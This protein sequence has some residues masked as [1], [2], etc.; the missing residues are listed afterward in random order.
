MKYFLFTSD[1]S[2]P[3]FYSLERYFKYKFDRELLEN[4]SFSS[5]KIENLTL[6]FSLNNPESLFLCCQQIYDNRINPDKLRIIGYDNH[7]DINLLN[8]LSLS[9]QIKNCFQ[10]VH[11]IDRMEIPFFRDH[12]RLFFNGHGEKSLLKYLTEVNNSLTNYANLAQIEEY[13]PEELFKNFL[14][15]GVQNWFEFVRRFN[16]Y[17]SL[18]YCLGWATETDSIIR[19]IEKISNEL[20]PINTSRCFTIFEL[21]SLSFI[22]EIRS[23]L[24]QI[25]RQT[26]QQ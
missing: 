5:S 24:E 19:M 8:Y 4:S 17:V 2:K 13:T 9:S 16:K 20:V 14:L 3:I 10:I 25:A 6:I 21:K 23:L 22:Y 18:L 1:K 11:G 7:N 26:S 12:I 15:Q